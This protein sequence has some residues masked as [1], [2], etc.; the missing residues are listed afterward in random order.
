MFVRCFIACR[1]S[2]KLLFSHVYTAVSSPSH[3]LSAACRYRCRQPQE[4]IRIPVVGPHSPSNP[5]F[6]QMFR[7]SLAFLSFHYCKY[8]L[9]R[10]GHHLTSGLPKTVYGNQSGRLLRPDVMTVFFWCTSTRLPCSCC[11]RELR[12][13]KLRMFSSCHQ[14]AVV[15]Q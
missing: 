13:A 10:I 4:A 12:R 6:S 9:L 7:K 1:Q 8:C 11:G 14:R 15:D 2:C 3:L 5:T